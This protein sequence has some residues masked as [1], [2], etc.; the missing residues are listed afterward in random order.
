MLQQGAVS[1]EC[2]HPTPLEGLTVMSRTHIKSHTVK[3]MGHFLGTVLLL[4]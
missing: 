3:L 1:V 4:N 2:N